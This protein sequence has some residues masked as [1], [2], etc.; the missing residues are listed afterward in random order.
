MSDKREVLDPD[1]P[2]GEEELAEANKLR[3]AL[4]HPAGAN[5]DAELAQALSAAWSPRDLRPD[6][7]RALLDRALAEHA[8]RRRRTRVVRVSFGAGAIAALAAALALVVGSTR[9]TRQ[10]APSASVAFVSTRS[11][12][13]L[14]REPFAS[15]GGQTA[16]IDRIAVARAADLRDNEFAKWGVR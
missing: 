15:T 13:A 1:A 12:Q 6:Q 8:S 5:R 9:D 10:A 2:P 11:T 4:A 3:D 7:H 16:R 14:F